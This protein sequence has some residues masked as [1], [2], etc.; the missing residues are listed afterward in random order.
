MRDKRIRSRP[1]ER[2][3]LLAHGVRAFCLTHGG[4]Y[5]KWETLELLVKRWGDMSLRANIEAGPYIYSPTHSSFKQLTVP[6]DHGS[7]E[8]S[9]PAAG[10]GP[11]T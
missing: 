9:S 3:K 6:G 7:D 1:W 10:H 2:Q 5:R 8:P 11:L 4:N